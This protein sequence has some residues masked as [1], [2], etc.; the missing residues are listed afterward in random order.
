MSIA[1]SISNECYSR[2]ATSNGENRK[3][4]I[5]IQKRKFYSSKILTKSVQKIVAYFLLSSVHTAESSWSLKPSQAF[6]TSHLQP[7]PRFSKCNAMN[8]SS[9]SVA[10]FEQNRTHIHRKKNLKKGNVFEVLSKM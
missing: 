9:F 8:I 5:K 3:K 1:L 4:Y 10:L 2:L 6:N 7:L